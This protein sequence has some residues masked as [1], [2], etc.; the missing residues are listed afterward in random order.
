MQKS[1][2]IGNSLGDIADFDW[3]IKK[4][5]PYLDMSIAK[6]LDHWLHGLYEGCECKHGFDHCKYLD[7]HLEDDS[8]TCKQ[9]AP[10]VC[11]GNGNTLGA[12]FDKVPKEEDKVCL[13]AYKQFKKLRDSCISL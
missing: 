9:T 12:V 4:C 1:T 3:F 11:Y 8:L 7:Y 5:K 6:Y 13:K 10:F 2:L